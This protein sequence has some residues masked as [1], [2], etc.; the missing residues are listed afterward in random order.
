MAHT[1]LGSAPQP[2]PEPRSACLRC[3]RDSQQ[4]GD[5]RSLRRDE[6]WDCS[7]P[8]QVSPEKV[9]PPGQRLPG[10]WALACVS[11]FS[12][13]LPGTAS[14]QPCLSLRTPG[15]PGQVGTPVGP[16]PARAVGRQC[17][18]Q[19]PGHMTSSSDTNT[20][21]TVLPYPEAPRRSQG[22]GTLHVAPAFRCFSLSPLCIG[23]LR[24][25]T[26][27]CCGHLG[28]LCSH[29]WTNKSPGCYSCLEH[30]QRPLPT[31]LGTWSGPAP[32]PLLFCCQ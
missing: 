25:P 12:L 1:V 4:R 32:A 10:P 15:P 18:I 19:I 31:C 7:Q 27:L 20:D 16:R 22:S 23:P 8:G 26:H 29:T 28:P 11:G 2:G 5:P 3:S 24:G 17:L 9:W 21:A 6:V 13:G 14:P 30:G